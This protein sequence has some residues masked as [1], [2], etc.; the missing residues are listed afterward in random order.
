MARVYQQFDSYQS[1]TD[2]RRR[3]RSSN[4][5]YTKTRYN[6]VQLK[7]QSMYV[8]YCRHW[9]CGP[10]ADCRFIANKVAHHYNELYRREGRGQRFHIS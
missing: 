7:R 1:K 4:F 5:S 2:R 6:T 3:C 8:C 9:T 10:D